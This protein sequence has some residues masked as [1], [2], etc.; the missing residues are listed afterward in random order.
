MASNDGKG[1]LG[2]L[3]AL[4]G[5]VGLGAAVS[6]LF[7]GKAN[8]AGGSTGGDATNTSGQLGAVGPAWSAAAPPAGVLTVVG[9]LSTF[10]STTAGVNPSV[11]QAEAEDGNE[12]AALELWWLQN[13]AAI[14]KRYTPP[15]V[16][17]EILR[18]SI[19]FDVNPLL[20][21]TIAW[22]T[23]KGT[24][25][26]LGMQPWSSL[27]AG[28]AKISPYR[29]S[30]EQDAAPTALPLYYG[31]NLQPQYACKVLVASVKRMGSQIDAWSTWEG[32]ADVDAGTIYW[33]SSARPSLDTWWAGSSPTLIDEAMQAPGAQIVTSQVMALQPKLPPDQTA[34]WLAEMEAAGVT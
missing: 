32:S 5:L 17:A 26:P 31:Y 2:A 9:G 3:I 7:G 8:A 33:P 11:L 28:I 12:W 22:A 20:P 23:T 13:G 18:W 1:A 6:L 25:R 10:E 30:I 27:A 16:V 34:T 19:A 4:A 24:L 21:F 15:V 14:F 29:Y